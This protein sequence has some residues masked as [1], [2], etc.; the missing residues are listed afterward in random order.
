MAAPAAGLENGGEAR[1]GRTM[2]LP[3]HDNATT[4]T[5]FAFLVASPPMGAC[6]H[7]EAWRA[8]G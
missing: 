6:F 2:P 3:M 5:H 8:A 4:V 7:E 1:A